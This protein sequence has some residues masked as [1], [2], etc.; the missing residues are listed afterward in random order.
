VSRHPQN[1]PTFTKAPP[2]KRRRMNDDERAALQTRKDVEL[3]E[4]KRTAATSRGFLQL[5][6]NDPASWFKKY[7]HPKKDEP[8]A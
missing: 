7:V 3:E 2:A 4:A 6:H 1:G 5:M 8:E